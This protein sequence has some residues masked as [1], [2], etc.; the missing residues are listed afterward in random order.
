MTYFMFIFRSSNEA[1]I[2]MAPLPIDYLQSNTKAVSVAPSLVAY[3][4]SSAPS[5]VPLV[6]V[7]Q[8]NSIRYTKVPIQGGVQYLNDENNDHDE[9]SQTQTQDIQYADTKDTD[10]R[11]NTIA[12]KSKQLYYAPRHPE[13]QGEAAPQPHNLAHLHA[14]DTHKVIPLQYSRFLPTSQPIK[15]AHSQSLNV[16]PIQNFPSAPAF[17]FFANRK[18]KSLL[19]S[20]IPSWVI[21]QKQNLLNQ[22]N[23]LQ[24]YPTSSGNTYNTI[25]YSTPVETESQGQRLLYYNGAHFKRS[26]KEQKVAGEKKV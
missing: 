5:I 26:T 1:Y 4:H 11:Q 22:N 6:P 10:S 24:H 15:Y 7:S 20:Y 16:Q 14:L 13:K 25:A 23:L 2:M 19:D 9:S 21:I 3:S 17:D 8:S 18:A 12:D